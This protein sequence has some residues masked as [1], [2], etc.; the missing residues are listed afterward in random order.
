MT[1]SLSSVFHYYVGAVAERQRQLGVVIGDSGWD[2]DMNTGLLSFGPLRLS[3]QV[4][5]T[6]A[7]GDRSWLWA[8]GNAQSGIPDQLTEYARRL[9]DYGA[10]HD[11]SEFTER[12]FPLEVANGHQLS[13]AATGL[14]EGRAYYRG[15]YP[16][17]AI[18]LV[19]TDAKLAMPEGDPLRRLLMGFPQTLSAYPID[20]HVDALHGY[21]TNLGLTAVATDASTVAITDGT[22]R[23]TATFDDHGRL[24]SLQSTLTPN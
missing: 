7:D 6:E 13:V 12:S 18:Y 10:A 2:F 16:G 5:G 21:A 15:P 8:W 19:I 23:A 1:T 17:G 11:I 9:R 4:L 14:L 3:V 20:R 24:A 22:S